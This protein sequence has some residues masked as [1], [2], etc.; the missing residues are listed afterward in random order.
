MDKFDVYDWKFKQLVKEMQ[1]D[2]DVN[3]LIY[4]IRNMVQDFARSHSDDENMQLL[5]RL[6]E[7]VKY[8]GGDINESINQKQ[9]KLT[10]GDLAN[11]LEAEHPNLRFD[12]NELSDRIDVRGSQK[13]LHDFGFKMQGQT[14]GEYEVFATDDEDRG[15]IVRIVRSYKIMRENELGKKLNEEDDRC[16]RIAKRKY[17]V[18][19]SAY[20]SG[21]VVRC[22]KGE[23]WKNEK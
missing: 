8:Y 15:E 13:D 5:K 20:A 18:W 17:D 12:V 11:Q 1:E 14:F 7:L 6:A 21:A 3:D 19:P 9:E 10:L 23:I 22:R 2:N 4:D 16:T